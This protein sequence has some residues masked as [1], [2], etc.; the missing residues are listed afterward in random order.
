AAPD[1]VTFLNALYVRASQAAKA[2][3]A[4]EEDARRWSK[5][6]EDGDAEARQ[7][8][9]IF[10]DAS[11]AEFKRVYALLGVDFDSWKGEAHYEDKM[12][13]VLAELLAKGLASV[14]QGATVV[15]LAAHGRKQFKKPM[16]L[17][18]ADGGTLY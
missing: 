9:Q 7:L 16:L 12:G 14:D 2:D 17:K 13:P 1:Q 11:L 8:W 18:R 5:A 6:L 3:P 10:K 15:D 4:L